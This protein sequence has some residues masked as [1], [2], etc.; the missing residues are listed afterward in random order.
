MEIGYFTL[1]NLYNVLCKINKNAK[2]SMFMSYQKHK[3]LK[4][5]LK[6]YYELLIV[7]KILPNSP[8]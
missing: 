7:C 6:Y 8:I 2:P 1:Q 4:R 3:S 5:Q